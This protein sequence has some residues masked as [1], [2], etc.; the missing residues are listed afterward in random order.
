MDDGTEEVGNLN[1]S[2]L[3]EGRNLNVLRCWRVNC[4]LVSKIYHPKS[5]GCPYDPVCI[6]HQL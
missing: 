3:G 6:C 5:P 4:L 2:I 1:S